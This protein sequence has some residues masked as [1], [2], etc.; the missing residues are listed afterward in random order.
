[1]EYV[2]TQRIKAVGV[3][4][5]PQFFR[6]LDWALKPERAAAVITSTTQPESRFS[7]YQYVKSIT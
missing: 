6:I 5:L 2:L 1:M 4:Y 3:K 7:L